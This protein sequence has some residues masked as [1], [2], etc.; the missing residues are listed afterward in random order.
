MTIKPKVT[1]KYDLNVT[2]SE[3]RIFTVLLFTFPV[4]LLIAGI[5]VFVLRRRK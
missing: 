4:L 2:T 3:A 5:V 1:N